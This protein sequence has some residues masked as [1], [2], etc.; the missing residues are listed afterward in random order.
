MGH[1]F[2]DRVLEAIAEKLRA[3]AGDNGFA[4]RLGG[5]EFTFVCD[6][7]VDENAVRR[8]GWELVR[9][10][11]KPIAVNGRE[12]VIG[13][14]VGAAF[15]RITESMRSRCCVQRMRRCSV[16]KLSGAVSLPSSVPSCW[17]K[18]R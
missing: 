8:V 13:I 6:G 11:Q 1:A 7:A 9:A 12:L 16:P 3:T 18:H 14:S 10:F 2:G 4:A 5:D 15:F 17:R